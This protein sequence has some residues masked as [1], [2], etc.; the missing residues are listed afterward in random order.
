MSSS[1]LSPKK[2]DDTKKLINIYGIASGMSYLHSH[3]VIHRD[4]KLENI[5]LDEYLNP[6]ISDF[7]LS[8]IIDF[9]SISMNVQSQRG[10]KGTPIYIAPEI[11]AEEEYSKSSDV[12]AFAFIVY[13]IITYFLIVLK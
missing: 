3:K 11:Y 7:G 6:K 9:L 13:E 2:W 10:L 5:L 1:G 8:K 4:L 12:Y